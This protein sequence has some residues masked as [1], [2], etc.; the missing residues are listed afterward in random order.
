MPDNLKAAAAAAGLTP[1]ERKAM[2]NLSTT[3]SVHRELSNLPQGVAQQ[4]YNNKTARSEEH[5]S[6]LQSH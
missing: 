5:T 6:E 1:E 4:A 3:L 2:E